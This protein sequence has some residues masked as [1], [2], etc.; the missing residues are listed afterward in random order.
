MTRGVE[1]A[2]ILAAGRGTR[3]GDRGERIPK[4]FL[5][6]GDQPIVEE[7]LRRL[8]EAGI[9]RTLIVTGRLYGRTNIIA[10]DRAGRVSASS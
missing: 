4:G 2:V 1:Q 7:S 3:L 5:T 9:R 6:L 8:R 10:L